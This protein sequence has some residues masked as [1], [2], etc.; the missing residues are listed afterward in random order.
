[1]EK[2]LPGKQQQQ[3]QKKPTCTFETW[4]H[5]KCCHQRSVVNQRNSSTALLIDRRDQAITHTL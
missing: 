1:M 3:Q 5:I 4:S 2:M